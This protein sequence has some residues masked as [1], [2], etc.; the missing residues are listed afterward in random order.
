MHAPERHRCACVA[1]LLLAWPA[2]SNAQP[3]PQTGTL[4][5][6]VQD[7]SGAVIPGALVH[8][9]G[10]EDSTRAIVRENLASDSQGVAVAADL[11][12]GQVHGRGELR[13]IR[14]AHRSP[15]CGFAPA[16]TGVR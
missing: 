10:A 16:T 6:V 9:R 13:R 5:V 12:P 4:R 15:T 11:V 1:A 2:A 8:V 3:R 14:D 7:P